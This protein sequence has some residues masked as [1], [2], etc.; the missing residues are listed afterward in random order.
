MPTSSPP[1]LQAPGRPPAAVASALEL[2]GNTP[3]IELT[4]IEPEDRAAVFAKLELYNPAGSVKDRLGVG[5]IDWAEEN[6]RLAEG[7]TIVEPTA[8]NTGI[9]L[10]LVGAQRGYRVILCV[11]ENF[12]IEKQKLM[13]ALGGTVER[14]PRDLGMKGAIARAHEIAAEIP[15]ACVPQQFECP[16]NPD[17]HYKTTAREI[18]EQMDGRVDAM[19]VGVGSGGT[20]SGMARFMRDHNPGCLCVAVEPNGSILQGGEPGPH[21]VEGIGVSFLP[22]VLA[23]DLIDEV[24]MVHDDDAFATAKLVA[25]TEGLLIGGSSG[26]CMNAALQIARRLGPGKRVVTVFADS[27]ERYIS[28]GHLDR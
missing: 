20:F 18:W 25:R 24:I 28:K 10:A 26:A 13:E 16:G 7:G 9:G 4:R 22:G 27:A 11:P 8:G 23:R 2:I 5:L 17:V 6:G 1:K 15:G 14:T 3:L 21:D 12:S 19:V